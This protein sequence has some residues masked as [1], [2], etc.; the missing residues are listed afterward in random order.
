MVTVKSKEKNIEWKVLYHKAFMWK[1][2]V[3]NSKIKN[4]DI[5]MSVIG[6][7]EIQEQLKN[8]LS[9]DIVKK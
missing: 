9:Y 2:K 6:K 3:S 8:Y 4:T 7:F 1:K 5:K